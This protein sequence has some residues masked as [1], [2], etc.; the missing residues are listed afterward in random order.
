MSLLKRLTF[1]G[2]YE[3]YNNHALLPREGRVSLARK[4]DYH[5]YNLSMFDVLVHEKLSIELFV[6]DPPERGRRQ[7]PRRQAGGVLPPIDLTGS[8][9]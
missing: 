7:A 1:S 5:L 4:I 9:G 8:C 2:V 3:A 6:D